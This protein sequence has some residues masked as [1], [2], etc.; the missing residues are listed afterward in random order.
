[1]RYTLFPAEDVPDIYSRSIYRSAL[2]R[3]SRHWGTNPSAVE[4]ELR[5]YCGG[6]T[7]LTVRAL[8]IAS[9]DNLIWRQ[10]A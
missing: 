1:M 6:L 4:S 3:L 10:A 5:G 7:D 8:A 2:K 9:S